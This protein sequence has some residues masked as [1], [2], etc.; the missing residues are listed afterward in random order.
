MNTS[1]FIKCSITDIFRTLKMPELDYKI[2]FMYEMFILC[3]MQDTN[4]SVKG[5]DSLYLGGSG[6]HQNLVG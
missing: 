6:A 4:D 3:C 1:S 2:I 5:V